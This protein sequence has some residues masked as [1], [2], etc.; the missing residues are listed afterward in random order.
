MKV[1]SSGNSKRVRGRVDS[2][3]LLYNIPPTEE[4]SLEEFEE[5]A[6]A[7]LKVLKTVE[8]FKVFLVA[9]FE[10]MHTLTKV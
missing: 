10:S 1:S 5:M 9:N 6:F 8:Q 2:Q 3:M 4:V 7:R